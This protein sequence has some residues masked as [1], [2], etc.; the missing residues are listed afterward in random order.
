MLF[1]QRDFG[2]EANIAGSHNIVDQD[3]N[4]NINSLGKTMTPQMNSNCGMP[5][6]GCTQPTKQ[7]CIHKTIVH[8][9][10]NIC[11]VHTKVIN[12]HVYRH[13]YKPMYTCSEECTVSNIQCGSCDGY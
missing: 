1:R 9:V 6:T 5:V 10:V 12:H 8:D 2:V 3:M 4:I 11:P 7:K 13:I